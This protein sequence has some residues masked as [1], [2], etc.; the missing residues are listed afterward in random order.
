MLDAYQ[1]KEPRLGI[2]G[3][4]SH[5]QISITKKVMF[6]QPIQETSV[7]SRK[8]GGLSAFQGVEVWGYFT[9]AF[10]AYDQLLHLMLLIL[11]TRAMTCVCCPRNI[12]LC[13]SSHW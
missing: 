1:T 13:S 11:E 6:R 4:Q 12:S 8:W 3:M 5:C 2:C 7:L 10:S 9:V